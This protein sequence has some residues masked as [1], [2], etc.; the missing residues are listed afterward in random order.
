MAAVS[1]V[2][3]WSL[4]LN[5]L[6]SCNGY[7]SSPEQ[8]MFC[9]GRSQ[10]PGNGSLMMGGIG[11]KLSMSSISNETGPVGSALSAATGPVASSNGTSGDYMVNSHEII[12]SP[13]SS[14]EVLEL[15][16]IIIMLGLGWERGGEE[17]EL[18]YKGWGEL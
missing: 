11:S 1:H 9:Y 10:P 7:L 13:Q 16:G 6:H 8:S 14:Y 2:Q 15:L 17:S 3:N 5:L 4:R 18:L 12:T